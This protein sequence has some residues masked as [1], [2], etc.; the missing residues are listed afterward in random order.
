ME[1]I[2]VYVQMEFSLVC[3]KREHLI[4]YCWWSFLPWKIIERLSTDT[5]KNVFENAIL[6]DAERKT[7][8]TNNLV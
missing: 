4:S 1:V 2:L 6:D 5:Q 3:F 7:E 8:H